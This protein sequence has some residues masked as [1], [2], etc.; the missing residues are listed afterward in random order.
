MRLKEQIENASEGIAITRINSENTAGIA[1]V[2]ACETDFVAKNDS[3]KDLA[4]Q[5]ADIA[6]NHTRQ[7]FIYVS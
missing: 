4:D 7:R 1:I 5:F 2:L 6:L 3:F